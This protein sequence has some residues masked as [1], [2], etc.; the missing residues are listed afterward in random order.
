MLNGINISVQKEGE[1]YGENNN[2]S[3]SFVWNQKKYFL[4]ERLSV[5]CCIQ[6]HNNGINIS[7]E[8]NGESNDKYNLLF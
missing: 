2:K 1:G 8:G 7:A 4:N 5:Q 3:K 6:V